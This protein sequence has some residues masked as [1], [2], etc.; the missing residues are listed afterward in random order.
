[1]DKDGSYQGQGRK[2]GLQGADVAS[3]NDIT[4]GLGN[5]FDI[6]G[7]TEI[8]RILG[9]GWTAGSVVILQFDSNPNVKH[10]TAAG[11]GYYGLQLDGGVDFAAT[12]GD[13]LQLV[14]DGAWWRQVE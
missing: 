5:Y 9:T 10:G 2:L 4:L 14:F 8:Q 11:S 7:A 12:A 1:V 6:T 13:T 3:A